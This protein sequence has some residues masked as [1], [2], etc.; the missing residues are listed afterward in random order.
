MP[1]MRPFTPRKS[2][3]L[4][5]YDY[6]ANGAYFVTLCTQN[7]VCLF[8]DIVENEM[9]LNDSGQMLLK[10]WDELQTKFSV[11]EFDSCVVMPNHLHAII[12]LLLDPAIKESRIGALLQK[13]T[14]DDIVQWFKT[15]TTNAYIRG[16]KQQG[17]E[18]FPGKLWQRSFHDHIIRNEHDLNTHRQYILSNPERWNLDSDNP[19]VL[20][21][22]T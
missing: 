22:P 1:I 14:L 19:N 18:T 4:Q 16:V 10:W 21:R 3:R 5:G 7:R 17:W 15:M 12:V 2:P 8:G 13:R 9:H 11:V 6:S 20:Q